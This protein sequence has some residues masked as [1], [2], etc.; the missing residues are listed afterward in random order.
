M[1]LIGKGLVELI[2]RLAADYGLTSEQL[3]N[4]AGAELSARRAALASPTLRDCEALLRAL[5]HHSRD[6]ALGLRMAEA[7]DLRSMGFWGYALRSALTL[8]Q[9]LQLHIQYLR[10]VNP[11]ARL[12]LTQE[13]EFGL[14]EID[15]GDWAPDLRSITGDLIVA[16][17]S[18]HQAQ[19]LGVSPAQLAWWIPY[20]EQPHHVRLRQLAS[21]PF[22]FNTPVMRVRVALRELDRRLAGDPYLLELA[23]QQLAAQVARLEARP[24]SEL[25][26]QV[27]ERLSGAH[28]IDAS[29]TGVARELRVSAR[30]LRRQLSAAG[31]PF[32]RLLDEARSQHAV[33][34]LRDSDRTIKDIARELGYADISNFQRAFRRWLGTTP[35]AYRAQQ[36]A[37]VATAAAGDAER[38]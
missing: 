22:E 35:A 21:G 37:R 26:A 18:L 28:L 9:R 1:T 13:G 10:F 15:P 6:P 36:R 8:R 12:Q 24:S 33:S 32:R 31:V 14:L 2:E 11:T 25:V 38:V 16:I 3:E 30:T 29:L 34:H 19:H 4:A 23:Q 7:F 17:T 5:A 20:P 27:R